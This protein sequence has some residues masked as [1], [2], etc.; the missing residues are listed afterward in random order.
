MV[1][2][3]AIAATAMIAFLVVGAAATDSGLCQ[4]VRRYRLEVSFNWS[5][6][7]HP[8]AYPENGV[9]SPLV[10]A[11]HNSCYNIWTPGC[12]VSEGGQ[13]IAET[14]NPTQLIA[15]LEAQMGRNVFS[16]AAESMPT[17]DGTTVVTLDLRLQGHT[18]RTQISAMTML[19]PSPDWFTGVDNIEM[20][21]TKA[22]RWIWEREGNLSV[23]D[24]G[25]ALGLN[26]LSPD[27]ANKVQRPIVSILGSRF[28]GIPVGTWK[29][30]RI[31]N[32]SRSN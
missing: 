3:M 24:A 30:Y 5:G 13:E 28:D 27:R 20:C 2:M 21:D 9:F 7:S 32:T 4:G 15:E 26:F 1:K 14:G 16:Y 10:A 6:M 11:A 19:F 29:I 18:K 23:W 12:Y 8:N 25:T 31:R 22:G 17:E